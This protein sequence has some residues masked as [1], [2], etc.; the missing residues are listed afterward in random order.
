MEYRY[1]P[2]QVLDDSVL[3]VTFMVTRHSTWAG[4]LVMV[5]L[6]VVLVVLVVDVKKGVVFPASSAAVTAIVTPLGGMVEV[7]CTVR[8]NVGP[9]AAACSPPFAAGV[10]VTARAA[11]GVELPFPPQDVNSIPTMSADVTPRIVNRICKSVWCKLQIL[12][13]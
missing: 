11:S 1:V 5:K 4:V 12:I 6:V 7:T 9:G 2:L 3:E 8:E 13:E 10:V